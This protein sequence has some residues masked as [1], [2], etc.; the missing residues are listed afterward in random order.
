M[1]RITSNSH[2]FITL[3]I[4][5][6]LSLGT[7]SYAKESNQKAVDAAVANPERSDKDRQLDSMR[8]PGEVLAFF[9]IKRGM[10]VLDVFG[11]GGYYT[12]ILSYLVGEKGHVTLYNNVPW[13]SFVSKALGPRLENN[14]LPNVKSHIADPRDLGNL[15]RKYDAAIFILGLHDIYYEDDEDWPLIDKKQFIDDIYSAIKPG[16]ILGI[17]DHNAIE[18]SDPKVVSKTLHRLDPAVAINDLEKAGFKLV[19]NS[20]LLANPA[21][22]KTASVFSKEM[23]RKTDRSLLLFTK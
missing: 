12:E 1:E 14:R 8:K 13:E 17:V 18:G 23:R 15:N 11:G 19:A 6:L 2:I 20:D 16:G 21:D 9:G 22:P 7:T 10:S 3:L 5:F 4:S